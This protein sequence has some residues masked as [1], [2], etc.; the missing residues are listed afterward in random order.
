MY[1]I[2]I[3]LIKLAYLFYYAELYMKAQT[4]RRF[5]L[6]A[7]T[8]IWGV[9]NIAGIFIIFFWCAPFTD[10]WNPLTTNPNCPIL[11]NVSAFVILGVMNIASDIAS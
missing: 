5:A 3:C 6:P 11:F 1:Y 7:A 4:S 8:A 10:N 2:A 9:S